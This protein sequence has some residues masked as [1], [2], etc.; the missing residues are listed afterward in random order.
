M[1]PIHHNSKMIQLRLRNVPT[2]KD[3]FMIALRASVQWVIEHPNVKP[4]G[5]AK[6]YG[7]LNTGIGVPYQVQKRIGQGYLD[8][9]LKEGF[10]TLDDEALMQHSI[11]EMIG[12]SD[13]AAVLDPTLQPTIVTKYEPTETKEEETLG[14]H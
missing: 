14:I 5:E 2:F 13:K 3:E 8:I 11:A 12:G 10:D 1:I 9:L 7:K 4:K 6:A